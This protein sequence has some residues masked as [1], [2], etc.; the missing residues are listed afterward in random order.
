MLFSLFFPF[1]GFTTTHINT[2]AADINVPASLAFASNMDMDSFDVTITDD[3]L[4]EETECFE[5]ELSSASVGS[6]DE[7]HITT[8]VCIKDDD[9]MSK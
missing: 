7:C 9:R 5:I 8:T 1:L 3:M 6:P 4:V 2:E